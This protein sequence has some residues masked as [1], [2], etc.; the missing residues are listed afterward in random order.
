M[1]FKKKY[2]LNNQSY[3]KLKSIFDITNRLKTP[4][5]YD[6]KQIARY[7]AQLVKLREE[8]QEKIKAQVE[9]GTWKEIKGMN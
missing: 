4:E 9:F 3:Y 5:K 6:E 1:D 7:E 2:K 8:L